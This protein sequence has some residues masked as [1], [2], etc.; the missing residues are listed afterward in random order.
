MCLDR[1]CSVTN[2]SEV[3]FEMKGLQEMKN[4][5]DVCDVFKNVSS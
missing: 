3:G 2:L 4:E 1:A 5:N